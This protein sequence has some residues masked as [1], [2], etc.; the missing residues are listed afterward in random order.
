LWGAVCKGEKKGEGKSLTSA[1][2]RKRKICWR[3]GRGEEWSSSFRGKGERKGREKTP[4]PEKKRGKM[5]ERIYGK[6]NWEKSRRKEKGKPLFKKRRVYRRAIR[7]QGRLEEPIITA[8]KGENK[9]TTTEEA[10]RKKGG[11]GGGGRFW[12]R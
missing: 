12:R 5:V 1:G 11:G 10:E 6:E 4:V 3:K 8:E 9:K 2:E 7:H